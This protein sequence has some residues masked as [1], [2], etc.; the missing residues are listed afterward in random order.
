M[1]NAV[2]KFETSGEWGA[3]WN[4]RI[5]YEYKAT[6]EDAID[7]RDVRR[8][9]KTRH[10]FRENTRVSF[11]LQDV[12]FADKSGGCIY[13][14]LYYLIISKMCNPYRNTHMRSLQIL[15]SEGT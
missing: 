11:L 6:R 8:N 3:E 2:T 12:S 1:Y 14:L 4:R 13:Q 7:R 10:K 9:L 15:N 5:K